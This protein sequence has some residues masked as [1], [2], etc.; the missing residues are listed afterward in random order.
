MFYSIK[1]VTLVTRESQYL[2]RQMKGIMNKTGIIYND[3][4]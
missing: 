4:Q 1:S 3:I 2:H